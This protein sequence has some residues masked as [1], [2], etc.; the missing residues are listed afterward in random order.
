MLDLTGRL[1][2]PA[3]VEEFV[4]SKAT[5]KRSQ[6]IDKLLDSEAFCKHW[7][8]YWHD[9][10]VSRAT[11]GRIKRGG[12]TRSFETWLADQVRVRR[13]WGEIATAMMTA[14]GQV[15]YNGEGN[16]ETAASVY[17][18]C[19]SGA[20]AAVER[21]AET[22]RVFLGIQIQCAQC[23]DHP[24]D[25]WKRNQFHELT[26]FYSR[27]SDRLVRDTS[28]PAGQ[29]RFLGVE[30]VSRPRGEHQMPGQDDPKKITLTHP[31]FL[32]GETIA[33]GS[34]DETRRKALAD[35]VTSKENYWFS[36]AFANRVWGELMG[37]GFYQPVDNMGPLQQ[38]T[39]PEVLL[40]LAAHFRNSNYDIRDTYRII[41]N[42]EAYQRQTRLGESVFD[43]L[44]FAALYP[45]KLSADALWESL[46][47]VLGQ[48]QLGQQFRPQGPGARFAGRFGLEGQ[49]KETFEYDPSTRSDEI[50]GSVPQALMLMNNPQINQKV[51]ANGDTI[52]ARILN[53][54]SNN[55]DALKML[56]LRTLARKPTTRELETCREHIAGVGSRGE[57]FEDILWSLINSTE[58][59][60]KR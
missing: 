16:N 44:H 50:E 53:S 7:G 26:A 5:N 32:T 24:S 48:M 1:P 6:L 3:D 56:Y 60:T 33:R 21:A 18:L 37:Q 30:L 9:V 17:L 58:F 55:D 59:Q 52:L 42:T 40:S 47:S 28:A 41:M 14:S 27:V 11:D 31:R 43:H 10:I 25:M 39:Y 57:A 12:L 8:K 22:S 20:E 45:K 15:K 51:R 19:H 29:I 35:F 23:H 54:H 49:F 38:A 46:N 4:A 34:S 2:L 13:N 36:A